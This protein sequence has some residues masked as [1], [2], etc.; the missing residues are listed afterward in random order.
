MLNNF[1]DQIPATGA[2]CAHRGARS[3]APENTMAAFEMAVQCGAHLLETDVQMSADDQLLLFHDRGLKRTTDIT[4]HPAF[5]G[6]VRKAL[7]SFSVED[8]RLLDAG[9][10]FLD[11]DPYGTVARGFV[12]AAAQEQ[13]RTQ[14]IPLLRDLLVFCRARNF[15]VNLEI[16]GKLPAQK[17]RRRVDLLLNLLHALDCCHLVLLSSF[18]RDDLCLIKQLCPQLPTA[19]LAEFRHPDNLLEY[20]QDLQVAAYHPAVN[21]LDA[22]LVSML[23]GRGIRVNTWTV[24]DEERYAALARLGVT[25]ICSD[26]PQRMVFRER[27]G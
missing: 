11:K 8:L 25:F 21:L 18:Y 5:T 3:L 17:A 20:L 14:Q 24:N 1:F 6:R 10:W 26:W 4:A 15:P 23:C 27:T 2:I 19:A 22:E 7:T 9:T 13:I 16:K 12:T